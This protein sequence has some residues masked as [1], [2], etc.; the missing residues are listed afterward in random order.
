MVLKKG[1][2][3]TLCWRNARREQ[4]FSVPCLAQ[5]KST[6]HR[7]EEC[8]KTPR[9][10][11]LIANHTGDNKIH[12]LLAFLTELIYLKF[13]HTFELYNDLGGHNHNG[14]ESTCTKSN[15]SWQD[16]SVFPCLCLDKVLRAV[17]NSLLEHRNPSMLTCSWTGTLTK[18]VTTVRYVVCGAI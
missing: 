8:S 18:D 2:I 7:S 1:V 16:L 5:Q 13:F 4:I 12:T 17:W 3:T 6:S 9:P 15:S 14:R 11:E 10:L